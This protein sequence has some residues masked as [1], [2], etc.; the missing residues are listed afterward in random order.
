MIKKLYV[1]LI[2]FQILFIKY[3]F[4]GPITLPYDT[5]FTKIQT[6]MVLVSTSPWTWVPVKGSTD[7]TLQV[8]ISTSSPSSNVNA[9]QA[10]IWDVNSIS[11]NKYFVNKK[12][13]VKQDKINDSNN[14]GIIAYYGEATNIAIKCYGTKASITGNWIEYNNTIDLFDKETYEDDFAIPLSSPTYLIIALDPGTTVY[15]KIGGL[16]S[17]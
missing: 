13:E 4:A 5:D 11:E 10:G 2:V 6:I 3:L 14:P 1:F 8:S 7:G 16:K 17:K 12:Y 9:W 15:Y